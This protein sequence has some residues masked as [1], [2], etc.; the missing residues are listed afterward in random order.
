MTAKLIQFGMAYVAGEIS[1]TGGETGF[2]S[3]L[4]LNDLWVIDL[5]G[6]SQRM[7]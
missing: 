7:K 6:T 4:N 3:I 5:A 2:Y 1:L